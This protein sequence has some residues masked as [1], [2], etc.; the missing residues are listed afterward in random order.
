MM[1]KE[2]IN[3]NYKHYAD[4]TYSAAV[5]KGNLLFIS[6]QGAIDYETNEIVG[7]GDLLAQT[8]QIYKN[9]Q[10]ILEASG[11]S[12]NDVVK[13]TDYI[14]RDALLSYKDT[15]EIR[16]EYFKDSFPASTGVVVDRLIRSEMLIE[17]DV[18]AIIQ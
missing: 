10:K 1:E 4:V 17:V 18:V 16:K 15:S 12:F 7:K 8:R 11:A 2:V 14:V 13:T 6:G 5:K 3:L 9:I